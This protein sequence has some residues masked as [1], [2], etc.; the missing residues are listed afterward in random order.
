[1]YLV[2]VTLSWLKYL[3]YAP[4][5]EMCTVCSRHAHSQQNYV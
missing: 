1:M 4:E 2:G 3:R 5:I